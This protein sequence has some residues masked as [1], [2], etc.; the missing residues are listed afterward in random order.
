MSRGDRIITALDLG[1]HK[2]RV[3]TLLVS[4]TQDLKIIGYGESPS[5][6]IRR[7]QI[8]D[9]KEAVE[10]IKEA[11]SLA[12]KSG[13]VKISKITV[14]LGGAHFKLMDSKGAIAVSRA[15][16][17]ISQEDV[18]RVLDSARA[19]S[20]PTN[21]EI[22][23]TIPSEYIIDNDEKIKDPVGMHGVRLESNVVLVLGSTPV[24]KLV[25]KSVQDSGVELENI[26]YSPLAASRA[27]LT[28][29][30]KELGSVCVDIGSGSTGISVWEESELKFASVLPVGS[31]LITN[32]VAIGLR[33]APEL[34]EKVKTEFGCC[35]AANVSKREQLVLA[36]WGIENIIMSK[37]ELARIIEARLCEIFDMVGEELKKSG[38]ANFLPAGVVLSGGGVRLEGAIELAKKRL[39]LPVEI[40]RVREIKSDFGEFF[41]PD[42]ATL[43]GILL[44]QYENERDFSSQKQVLS[45]NKKV[46]EE[47]FWAKVKEW[48]SELIP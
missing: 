18:S 23:H 2:I 17:E 44:Y 39:K 47:G 38:K 21:R 15:D 14:G 41:N 48:F 42:S 45:S 27:V 28:K 32:D 40:G 8:I 34:S 5:H 16:G 43:A 19:I 26:V 36:D 37:F 13:N 30:Q 11:I 9:L 24:L 4:P 29:K 3:A 7:G 6:G 31:S 12:S 1:S 20:I 25:R 22:V 46:F 10:S 33:I 35:F